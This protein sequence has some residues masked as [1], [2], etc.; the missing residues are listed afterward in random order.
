MDTCSYVLI[1]DFCVPVH[2]TLVCC[3]NFIKC[4]IKKQLGSSKK[5]ST[6]QNFKLKSE[7]LMLQYIQHFKNVTQDCKDIRLGW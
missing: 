7:Q 5:N 3:S 6:F 1:F 2:Y 4:V